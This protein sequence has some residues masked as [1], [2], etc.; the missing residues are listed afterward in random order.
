MSIFKA[1][2]DKI[3]PSSH[4]AVAEAAP[5]AATP[6]AAPAPAGA[7]AA[8][9]AVDVEAILNGL[10][11][12]HPEKLNWKTSI[13]DLMKLLGLDSSLA[14]RKQLATELHYSGDTNDSAAMNI[15]LHKQVMQKLAENGGKVPDDLK[16]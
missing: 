1:I 10:A 12:K 6:T 3:F 14:A 7:P 15:W 2:L 11:A 16:K 4:P 5:P 8:M 9:P 13:V